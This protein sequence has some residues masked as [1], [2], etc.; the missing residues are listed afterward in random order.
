MTNKPKYSCIS[1]PLKP[2]FGKSHQLP[3]STAKHQ[4]G[5]IL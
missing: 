5:K 4:P 3:K 2:I 1:S